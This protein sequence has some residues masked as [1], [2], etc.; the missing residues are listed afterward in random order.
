MF[1]EFE[2]QNIE[3]ARKILYYGILNNMIGGNSSLAGEAISL[4][5]QLAELLETLDLENSNL[6]AIIS[7]NK[8]TLEV[9]P[10]V[11]IS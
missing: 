8:S 9:S 7:E 11:L 5:K 3:L 10:C 6:Q 4:Q 1:A 2:E